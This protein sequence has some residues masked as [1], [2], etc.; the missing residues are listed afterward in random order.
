MDATEEAGGP[1]QRKQAPL[2]VADLTARGPP[3]AYIPS[4]VTGQLNKQHAS[5]PPNRPPDMTAR[6]SSEA[7]DAG[8]PGTGPGGPTPNAEPPPPPP[9]N[10]PRGTDRGSRGRRSNHAPAC[11]S[12]AGAPWD[13]TSQEA[14]TRGPPQA[15]WE[16]EARATTPDTPR[17]NQDSFDAFMESCRS[18]PHTNRTPAAPR[19]HPDPRGDHTGGTAI[20]M[21]R[22]AHL[23]RDYAA[24]LNTPPPRM[25]GRDHK[26]G[27]GPDPGQIAPA[28]CPRER[29]ACGDGHQ[30]R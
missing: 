9:T 11:R 26:R 29:N 15:N 28:Q 8:Q 7:P 23:Q 21:S 27:S 10:R 25:T 12:N 2:P 4:G 30:H 6:E 16:P 22:Q 14:P 3:R 17:R 20:T 13:T 19:N 5:T 18:A 1:L 24:Q